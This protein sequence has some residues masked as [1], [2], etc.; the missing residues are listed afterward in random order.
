MLMDLGRARTRDTPPAHDDF[1]G[2]FVCRVKKKRTARL[3]KGIEDRSTVP[4]AVAGNHRIPGRED[5][6]EF[7]LAARHADG[8]VARLSPKDWDIVAGTKLV[9]DDLVEVYLTAG[10]QAWGCRPRQHNS[11]ASQMRERANDGLSIS[12]A[13]RAETIETHAFR[14]FHASIVSHW[15]VKWNRVSRPFWAFERT[16]RKKS[17]GTASRFASGIAKR[18]AVPLPQT[19]CN[20]PLNPPAFSGSH[21]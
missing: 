17:R 10:A 3:E 21:V 20:K 5:H 8:G 1:V 13:S 2:G 6:L 18:D 12:P 16:K 7:E 11:F 4:C 14:R 9:V 15:A 19:A